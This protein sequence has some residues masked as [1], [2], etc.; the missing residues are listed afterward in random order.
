MLACWKERLFILPKKV[1]PNNFKNWMCQKLDVLIG[2]IFSRLCTFF[3]AIFR[4]SGSHVAINFSGRVALTLPEKLIAAWES[5]P[6]N[7]AVKKRT[8]SRF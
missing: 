2:N 3:D 5:P 7:P 8:K 4:E 1:Y 6:R